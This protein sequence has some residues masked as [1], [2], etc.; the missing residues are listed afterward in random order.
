MTIEKQCGNYLK[1]KT[2]YNRRV[3]YTRTFCDKNSIGIDSKLL[4][5]EYFNVD[6]NIESIRPFSNIRLTDFVTI[7]FNTKAVV[8]ETIIGDQVIITRIYIEVMNS[9]T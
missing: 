2:S 3:E 7:Y 9:L 6:L 5:H 1:F 4:E 8:F